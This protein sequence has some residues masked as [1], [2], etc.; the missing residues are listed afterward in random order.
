MVVSFEKRK[1]DQFREGSKVV[2]PCRDDALDL[3]S[4]MACWRERSPAGKSDDFVFLNFPF[5]AN[6]RNLDAPIHTRQAIT[7]G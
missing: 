4:L 2:V 5:N 1:N 6:S 7:Y 3:V